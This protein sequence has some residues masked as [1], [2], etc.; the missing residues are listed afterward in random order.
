MD[1]P[2]V[3]SAIDE[4]TE[5][6]ALVVFKI[7]DLFC[8]VD[9]EIDRLSHYFLMVFTVYRRRKPLFW[10]RCLVRD[11]VQMDIVFL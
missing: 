3:V 11:D 2:A 5:F 8:S 9:M 1:D 7:C 6:N 10:N 4:E